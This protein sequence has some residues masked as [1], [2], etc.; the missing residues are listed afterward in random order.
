MHVATGLLV[1]HSQQIEFG[2]C[3]PACAQMALSYLGISR[4]Q[5]EIGRTLTVRKGIGVPA[6]QVVSLQTREIATQYY[7]E[8]T[9]TNVRNWLE[10]QVPVIA[11]IQAGELPHWTG[12]RF[13]HA[14]LVSGM[15]DSTVWL[16]DPALA[17][18]PTGVPLAD[19]LLAWDEIDHRFAVIFLRIE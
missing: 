19:F 4:S 18:G 16:H 11:F 9:L 5:Q 12:N 7:I 6:S 2:Y 8:G 3:L 13:Q 1:Q 15:D 10:K 17:D 14:V